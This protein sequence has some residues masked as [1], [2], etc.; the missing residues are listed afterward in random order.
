MYRFQYRV[1]SRVPDLER[2]TSDWR[3]TRPGD[4]SLSTTIQTRDLD[5]KFRKEGLRIIADVVSRGMG[6]MACN[7]TRTA[8]SL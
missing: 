3:V 8:D 7:T 1:S 6:K 4:P 2:G 5:T